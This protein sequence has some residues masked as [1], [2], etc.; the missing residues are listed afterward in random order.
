MNSGFVFPKKN[1]FGIING[2]CHLWDWVQFVKQ[3]NF[4][5]KTIANDKIGLFFAK[6]VEI[7]DSVEIE[8][9]NSNGKLAIIS[10]EP[11]EK[12]KI[13]FAAALKFLKNSIYFFF[14]AILFHKF[15]SF[16][17]LWNWIE[18]L[19]FGESKLSAS[20]FKKKQEIFQSNC[21]ISQPD[22]EKPFQILI[23]S[24]ETFQFHLPIIKRKE[25]E[26]AKQEIFQ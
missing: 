18:L 3:E 2:N 1:F 22:F 4:G 11:N 23:N 20:T 5:P 16:G 17:F 14:F 24:L 12:W 19:F 13:F 7:I 25:M 8:P 9:S 6:V 10:L 21:Y 15:P 26:T